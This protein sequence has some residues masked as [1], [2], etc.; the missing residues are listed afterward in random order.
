MRTVPSS[1][2]SMVVPVSDWI[3][4]TILPP[5]PMTSRTLSGAI[6]IVSMRGAYGVRE[7]FLRRDHREERAF[8]ERT[9]AD[10]ASA[11]AAQRPDLADRVR[12]EVVVVHEPLRVDRRK[13]VDDLLVA[14]RAERRDREDLGLPALKER[15]AMRP[16]QEPDLDRERADLGE[17][18]AVRPEA[19]LEHR[20]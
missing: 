18:A 11:R 20:A 7:L 16:R 6:L 8:R 19:L 17:P 10:L 2:S 5:G 4:R 1:S 12:R 3:W 13:R 9:V 14:G 15:G